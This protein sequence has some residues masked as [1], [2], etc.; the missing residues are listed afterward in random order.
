ME[1]Y[2]DILKENDNYFFITLK[3]IPHN[4]FRE[5]IN[6]L[7]FL[8]CK[9]IPE[10]KTWKIE[11]NKFKD[12]ENTVYNLINEIDINKDNP[13]DIIDSLMQNILESLKDTNDENFVLQIS[14]GLIKKLKELSISLNVKIYKG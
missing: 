13:Q 12:F 10:D 8:K 5:C 2:I 11:K 1:E 7:K 9:F 14:N 4:H 6:F 3:N